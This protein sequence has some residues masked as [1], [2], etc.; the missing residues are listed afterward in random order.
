MKKSVRIVL[1]VGF[2]VLIPLTYTLFSWATQADS[3]FGLPNNSKNYFQILYE[4]F[5]NLFVRPDMGSEMWSLSNL[6]CGGT[7]WRAPTIPSMRGCCRDMPWH[8]P[9]SGVV[10]YEIAR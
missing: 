10:P 2:W 9:T 1:H 4:G 6:C 8:V 5:V 3:F 7:P